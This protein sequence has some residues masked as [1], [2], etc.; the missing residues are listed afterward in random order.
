[1]SEDEIKVQKIKPQTVGDQS[2]LKPKEKD[3]GDTFD[4]DIWTQGDLGEVSSAKTVPLEENGGEHPSIFAANNK[5][6]SKRNSFSS[7]FSSS[8]NNSLSK[9]SSSLSFL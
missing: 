4:A 6:K 2:E 9:D 8:I 1:M 5:N 7:S 3:D